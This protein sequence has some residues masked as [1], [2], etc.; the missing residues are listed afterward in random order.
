MRFVFCLLAC[1][2][3][4]ACASSPPPAMPQPLQLAALEQQF[5]LAMQLDGAYPL[6]SLSQQ[7]AQASQ[8]VPICERFESSMDAAERALANHP[9]GGYQLHQ[10]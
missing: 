7:T 6:Q 9:A 1:L 5:S 8:V 3:M 10:L 2:S 4:A